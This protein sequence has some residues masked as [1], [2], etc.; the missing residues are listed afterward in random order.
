MRLQAWPA[1]DN[2][3]TIGVQSD[4]QTTPEIDTTIADQVWLQGQVVS[5]PIPPPP[6]RSIDRIKPTYTMTMAD[7]AELVGL[8][9]YQS[10]QVQG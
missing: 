5:D 1:P 9:M 2:N 8:S 3:P 7:M 6:P 4:Y 10:P